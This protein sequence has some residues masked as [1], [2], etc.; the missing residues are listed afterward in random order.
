MIRA[1]LRHLFAPAASPVPRVD[2]ERQRRAE[3]RAGTLP[4]NYTRVVADRDREALRAQLDYLVD[5]HGPEEVARRLRKLR[6]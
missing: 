5:V 1:L 4:W 3:Q 2:P 6:P